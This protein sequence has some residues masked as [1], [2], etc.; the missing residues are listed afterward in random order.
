[1][2]ITNTNILVNPA[3][4]RGQV[5]ERIL[6]VLLNNQK[7]QKLTKYRIVKLAKA[8]ISWVIEFLRK[9][10]EHDLVKG[11]RVKDYRGLITMWK[12][13]RIEPDVREY[14]VRDILDL[15]RK[16]N[17]K[18]ALTTYAAENLVQKHLFP[19]RTDFYIQPKDLSK[20]HNILSEKGLVGKG[21]VRTLMTD[22][23]VFYNSFVKDDLMVVSIPQMIVDLMSEGLVAA[24][25]ADMLIEKEKE[26]AVSRL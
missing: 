16:T 4:K 18:Y 26:N 22:E 8:N 2:D 21:N 6:R 9:L 14:M 11:T 13:I 25:A 5:K 20:W 10:E 19:S 17:M 3:P 7:E 12:N 15:L 1:M 24:E 23:H